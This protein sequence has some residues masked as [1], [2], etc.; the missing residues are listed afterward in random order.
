MERIMSTVNTS[1]TR[2]RRP[3]AGPELQASYDFIVC[4]SGSSGSVVARR[5]AENPD[6]N[7]LLL[8]AGSTD[9]VASVM[10]P[11]QWTT[12]LGSAR[13]WG[14]HSE[15]NAH[16]NGRVL[17]LPMGKVL[18]GG[19]SINVTIWARGHKTDWD[20]FASQSGE[21][22][23][24]YHAVLQIYRSIEDWQGATDPEH[25]GTG[26]PVFVA[27]P[28]NPHSTAFGVV[29]AAHCLGIG[30]YDSPNGTMMEAPGGASLADLR[31]RNGERESVYRSYVHPFLGRPNLTVLTNA[32]VQRVT[33]DHNRATGVEIGYQGATRRVAA[34]AEVVLSLGAIHTPKVLMQSG[35][36]DSEDLS[37]HGIPVVQHLPGVGQNFQDHPAFTC[38]WESPDVSPPSWRT[39]AV[40]YWQSSSGLD[41]PDLYAS[42]GAFPMASPE[43]TARYGLPDSS[44]VLFGALVRPKSRGRITLTGPAPDDPVRICANVLSHPD[45]VKT[46]LACVE[47]MREVGNSAALR[48]YVKRE[49]MPGNLSG[50]ELAAYLRDAAVT[51]WHQVGTAKMGRDAMSVVNGALKVYGIDGLRVA[52]GSIMPR[53]TTGATMAPCVVIGERA[54]EMIRAEHRL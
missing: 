18:G 11:D 19:S 46:A 20:F 15:P 34:Q 27:Q 2:P 13:D 6:V 49:V 47:G 28:P 44:W 22:A 41:G 29:E 33:I 14:F 4:G 50:A 39:D 1:Q 45:D 5:L 31:Q 10:K 52:D 54:S 43:N 32:M 17:P 53:L 8:E 16:L 42:Q 38:V 30:S 40:M 7:V 37:V 48:P 9:D 3:F 35:I 51:Y 24:N 26:G 36:G 23:W 21:P 12:N 25:R